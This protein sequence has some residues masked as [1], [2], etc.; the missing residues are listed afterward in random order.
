MKG[1]TGLWLLAATLCLLSVN[2][3][4][5]TANET[6]QLMKLHKEAFFDIRIMESDQA[7]RVAEEVAEFMKKYED[8]AITV[9]G[10]A[11]RET[12]NPTLNIYYARGRA[13]NFRRDLV[14]R[15]GVDPNRISVDW[16][17][18]RVQPFTENA[19]NRC[20][21]IDGYGYEANNLLMP[22][23]NATTRA[24]AQRQQFQDTKAAQYTTE[25]NKHAK[26]TIVISHVDTLW[27]G[28][29]DSL[30]TDS[31][32]GKWAKYNWF[33][34]LAAGPAIFQGD[35]NIDAVWSDRI[36]PAFDFSIGKWVLPAIGLR[37]GV[38]FDK[39]HNYYNAN[40][41]YPN[42]LASK[43][44]EFVHGASPDKP[45]SKRPWLYR[46]DYNAWNFH[47]DLMVNFSHFMW[48][49]YNRRLWNLI[50]YAGVGCI[51]TWD[52]GS[53]EWHNQDWFNYATSWNVG[54]LNSFRLTEHFD[55]N[56]DLRLKK[57]NDDF[58]CWRQGRDMDGTTDL[59]IGFTWHFTKRGF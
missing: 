55:F 17:G 31:I 57:F 45:Y 47:V 25:M 30:D 37:A 11:D 36:Y 19:R 29:K 8:V 49:P 39:I 43:Y 46:M 16:K 52:Q 6:R 23:R 12:G 10:Y 14:K 15:F 58:N 38:N 33:V 35:H 32:E 42:E 7:S 24:N 53:P 54:I 50:G 2:L 48:R 13:E 26:D 1:K 28:R 21:I 3:K 59:M 44:G 20:V 51:A 34:T 40:A 22:V 4:A 56:I 9:I 18:D 5:Q 41:N 27:L